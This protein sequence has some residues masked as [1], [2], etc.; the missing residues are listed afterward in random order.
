MLAS[1]GAA[2]AV[3]SALLAG[4]RQ[5][6]AGAV[7][8][9]LPT[10]VALALAVAPRTGKIHV[11]MEDGWIEL[12][13]SVAIVLALLARTRAAP[14]AVGLIGC[15]SVV[16]AGILLLEERSAEVEPVPHSASDSSAAH[17]VLITLDTVRGDHFDFVQGGSSP[18]SDTPTLSALADESV[19]FQQAFST[20]A[21]TGP[22]HA[23]LLSGLDS[24]AH[25]IWSN[26]D[27]LP[28]DIPW[29]PEI[30]EA[31]GWRTRAAV[32]AAV[33]DA[34]LGFNR[35]FRDFDSTFERRLRRG[36]PLMSFLGFR[37]H[38][39]SSHRRSGMETVGLVG[40]PP[41]G[42][43]T[44]T[45]VHLY[46][47]HWPYVPSAEAA[48]R[49]GLA[50]P[51]PLS[52][53]LG[54]QAA[55]LRRSKPTQQQVE[56]GKTLY[57]AGIDD[58]DRVVGHLL[59]RL[60]PGAAIVVVGDHGES[61]GEQGIVF[62]HGSVP[63]SS[64]THVPLIVHGDGWP[65]GAVDTVVSLMDVAPTLLHLAG[66]EPP[67]EMS[68]RSLALPTPRPVVSHITPGAGKQEGEGKARAG[69]IAVREGVWSAIAVGSD[70]PALFD[71]SADPLELSPLPLPPGHDL[72]FLLRGERLR[73][74]GET[75]EHL[76]EDT[77]AMLRSL[78][79]VE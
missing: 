60:P 44:F 51:T 46:D 30:L 25:G 17:I 23:T 19:V 24:P 71:R 68:G 12:V 61:L 1:V 73:M 38:R 62:N 78:G 27:P 4:T 28:A 31:Q 39:G 14:A 41:A 65:A 74:P 5:K 43:R 40:R 55:L 76:D 57:R 77:R 10:A 64:Q 13:V 75:P 72:E 11:R 9:L 6:V 34:S 18:V 63:Y 69:S 37:P 66:L 3:L 48:A 8:V 54:G 79:Y 59:D 35:G 52:P 49:H 29:V 56:R 45:W 20:S 22:S 33:L 15:W 70:P 32:S 53:G 67:D 2:V 50:D 16:A 26:G 36:H 42:H 21:L 47:A 7:P 58:L